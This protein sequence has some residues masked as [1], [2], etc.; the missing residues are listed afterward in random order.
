MAKKKQAKKKVKIKSL[1]IK[2]AFVFGL[3]FTLYITYLNAQITQH[4]SGEQ[5]S[6]PSRLYARPL[7]LKVGLKLSKKDLITELEL[8]SYRNNSVQTPG[9]FK[10]FKN[11][12][13]LNR[14][15]FKFPN[16]QQ[17]SGI[18]DIYFN[19]QFVTKITN[20]NTVKVESITLDPVLF[21]S[22]YAKN[23]EDRLV[24]EAKDIPQT[25]IDIL[26][27]VEDRQFINHY[28]VDPIAVLRAL[29]VNIQ[30]GKT[31]QGGS[32]LT[33]QLA[34]NLF[35]S[36]DRNLLRKINE[37]F[38][39]LLIEWHLSKQEILTTYVNQVYITQKKNVAVHGF[40]LAS[41]FLFKKPLKQLNLEQQALLVAMIKGPSYYHPKRHPKRALKRRNLVIDIMQQQ[42]IVTLKQATQLKSRS[43][44]LQ[45]KETPYKRFPAFVDLVKKQLPAQYD[46]TQLQTSG[47]RVF[48]TLDPIKQL[49][50]EQA[51]NKNKRLKDNAKLQAASVVIRY[52]TGDILSVVSDR[53]PN[54]PGF[55]R[56]ALAQRPIGSLIK[57]LLLYTLLEQGE[58]LATKVKD[59]P[60]TLKQSD[61]ALW[62]P[63]NYDS[64]LHGEVSLYQALVHSYNLPFVRIGLDKGLK[65]LVSLLEELNLQKNSVIYPSLLLGSLDLTPLEVSQLYQTIANDGL[66]TPLNSIRYI[67]DKEN[68]V[69]TKRAVVS[70]Q[71]LS[72]TSTAKVQSAMLGVT[73]K[74]TARYLKQVFPNTNLAGKTGTTDDYKDS[75][76]AGFSDHLL[77]VV[78]MGNDL[79]KPVNLTGASGALRLWADIFRHIPIRSLQ[80]ANNADL[81]WVSTDPTG[82]F[83]MSSNCEGSQLLPFNN[84]EAPTTEL[85]CDDSV[86]KRASNWLRE[87]F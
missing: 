45:I 82:Q 71:L 46:G 76:F 51:F 30:A 63:Q 54:F 37:A 15:P 67:T 27:A 25:L 64:Q 5:W 18:F 47:L 62:T 70:V 32:T 50:A 10:V 20:Q 28:G 59:R 75:W 35:L 11:R 34:K 81:Q 13:R 43:L 14:R 65:P 1:L 83:L 12:I 33:Q 4:I 44:G 24:V 42:S 87:L 9:S 21:S 41:Q 6:L 68:R 26:I 84:G 29:W 66:Y 80:N 72:K 38:Y 16:H 56:V 60:I 52:S 8:L 74:G 49:K 53:T 77:G 57:P 40:A 22:F 73:Q 39:A 58:S 3:T 23:G 86:L 31:V 48:T 55:N 7:L 17:Q 85:D 78:W 19:Q 61:G 36:S 79:N 2:S 69:L